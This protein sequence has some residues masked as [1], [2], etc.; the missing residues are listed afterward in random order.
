MLKFS[1]AKTTLTRLAAALLTGIWL[2]IA[3]S[4]ALSALSPY[5]AEQRSADQAARLRAQQQSSAADSAFKP[6]PQA[7]HATSAP[8][9]TA[10]PSAQSRS[11]SDKEAAAILQSFSSPNVLQHACALYATRKEDKRNQALA[12][13]YLGEKAGYAAVIVL[14][15]PRQLQVSLNGISLTQY[16]IGAQELQCNHTRIGEMR[17]Y[18][19]QALPYHGALLQLQADGINSQATLP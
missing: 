4:P 11:L 2:L 7:Q 6:L 3:A 18:N 1:S 10:K 13:Y 9:S 12:V 15:T 8:T 16:F 19:L 14:G 5:S 17:L